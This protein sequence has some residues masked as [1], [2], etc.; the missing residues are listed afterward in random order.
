MRAK[1]IRGEALTTRVSLTMNLFLQLAGRHLHNQDM[2]MRE[3]VD[4]N[5]ARLVPAI[6]AAFDWE[7]SPCEY[8]SSAAAARISFTNSVGD[9]RRAD[10][11]P[12]GTS[13][14]IVGIASDSP[15]S[16]YRVHPARRLVRGSKRVHDDACYCLTCRRKKPEAPRFPGLVGQG[17]RRFLNHSPGLAA[18]ESALPLDS[19]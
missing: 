17:S 11:A 19:Q 15:A 4:E 5:S 18:E 14:V 1:R 13:N 8:H 6:S 16:G 2:Q 3:P 12:S 10:S 9:K 7:I